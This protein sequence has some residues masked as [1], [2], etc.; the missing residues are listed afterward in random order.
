[1]VPRSCSS[2]AYLGKRTPLRVRI[3]GPGGARTLPR[4]DPD[5]DLVFVDDLAVLDQAPGGTTDIA[6][7]IPGEEVEANPT[8][9]GQGQLV[10]VY[11]DDDGGR[12]IGGGEISTPPQPGS[13]GVV[14]HADG[15]GKRPDEV[16]DR[17]MVWLTY[18]VEGV[19]PAGERPYR[20]PVNDQIFVRLDGRDIEGGWRRKEM[21][22][23]NDLG[24]PGEW[25]NGMIDRLY[26]EDINQVAFELRK[27]RSTSNAVWRIHRRATDGT[28]TL[29]TTIDLSASGP[30]DGS[31]VTVNVPGN[32]DALYWQLVR[33]DE[34]VHT[35][36]FRS[37]IENRRILCRAT[38]EFYTASDVVRDVATIIGGDQTGIDNTSQ[39][40]MPLDARGMSMG[41]VLDA[42]TL[43]TNRPWTRRRSPDGETVNWGFRPWLD[44]IWDL[45]SDYYTLAKIPL[46][47]YNVVAIPVRRE[48]GESDWVRERCDPTL[49]F[50]PN[51]AIVLR[52]PLDEPLPPEAIGRAIARNFADAL[53]EERYEY[54]LT[55]DS[56]E[57]PAN[58]GVAVAPTRLNAGHVVRIPAEDN[59]HVRVASSRKLDDGTVEASTKVGDGPTGHPW[60]DR[61][62]TSRKLALARGRG[63]AWA[64]LVWF[65]LERPKTLGNPLV[66][67]RETDVRDGR[68]DGD[69]IFDFELP[70]EDIE[71]NGTAIRAVIGELIYVDAAGVP[72]PGLEPDK[73]RIDRKNLDDPEADL[74][75]RIVWKGLRRPH[76]WRPQVRGWA[77]DYFGER[78]RTTAYGPNPP[79]LPPRAGPPTPI[80]SVDV[81][82][83][84]VTARFAGIDDAD[85]TAGGRPMLD[86]RVRWVFAELYRNGVLVTNSRR[87]FQ[88]DEKFWRVTNPGNATYRVDAWTVDHY[89]TSSAVGS[90]SNVRG[91]PTAP[92]NYPT[93]TWRRGGRRG[94]RARV[95]I[96][97]YVPGDNRDLAAYLV[98]LQAEPQN[99]VDS[100]EKHPLAIY[101]EPGDEAT[102]Q[103][104]IFDEYVKA[105]H[106]GRVR[107]A[108]RDADGKVST[109]G[110]W[111][112]IETASVGKRPGKVTH[113]ERE[114]GPTWIEWSWNPPGGWADGT[115]IG[116]T[117]SE[118]AGYR[119]DVYRNGV[120]QPE[121]SSPFKQNTTH[122]IKVPKGSTGW[123]RQVTAI[124]WDEE[125]DGPQVDSTPMAEPGLGITGSD[126]P[127]GVVD[128]SK[129]ASSL[130]GFAPTGFYG[131]PTTNGLAAPNT[132]S[133]L[134][135]G[136]SGSW[137]NGDMVLNLSESPYRLYKY[138][139]GIWYR[140][141]E[142][143]D[144]T[145]GSILA[146]NI[147]A[148]TFTGLGF[149]GGTFRSAVGTT[150]M[151]LGSGHSASLDMYQSGVFRGRLAFAGD[152]IQIKDKN[153]VVRLSIN[154]G[155]VD[156][157]GVVSANNIQVSV[158]GHT[159][160]AASTGSH[161]HG[162]SGGGSHDHGF[163]TH[164]GHDHGGTTGTTSGHSHTIPSG[165]SHGHSFTSVGDHTHG[166]ATLNDGFHSHSVS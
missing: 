83:Q 112:P 127:A 33:T 162:I 78:S 4:T 48:G 136:P 166:G 20:Y 108:V 41:D 18:E 105:G 159:H 115:T 154:P 42:M 74:P 156:L 44:Q 30:A 130:P 16:L 139:D 149:Y 122:R 31:T 90:N 160:T 55:L 75:T 93:L 109:F 51:D 43:R 60:I 50:A 129:L 6:F 110:P 35:R 70:T 25:R 73:K 57:D 12:C 143:N 91:R 61:V 100:D 62:I 39:N 98:Q 95:A 9:Y 132:R 150:Y 19:Q 155:A 69:C 52:V 14:V 67:F 111:S 34:G 81:D 157:S 29:V 128:Y 77:E 131:T 1:M 119:V 71:G 64:S 164:T 21:F 165:G 86:R 145:A 88:D 38:S 146:D 22:R 53:A 82:S 147:T 36:A 79:V 66:G 137:K 72:I 118:V 27:N 10:R 28:L 92:L 37:R 144:L 8:V 5:S 148:G 85:R 135:S 152:F 142:G 141:T 126:I 46:K 7:T 116:W 56:L 134:V 140:A 23:R 58:P 163:T 125:D 121:K 153:D 84:R 151:E 120:L 24:N 158:Q 17:P 13:N 106:R 117:A 59:L 101:L 32:P 96:S 113:K 65:D 26:D 15:D 68:W 63:N 114:S 138:E 97:G 107:Y 40:V 47:R 54:R 124:G 76:E 89:G 49:D 133:R 161:N 3:T 45:T 2:V 87:R 94:L 102:L 103:T 123:T 80:V 104:G 99:P 11:D